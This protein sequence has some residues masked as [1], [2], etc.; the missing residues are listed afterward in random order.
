V[1]TTVK[2]EPLLGGLPWRGSRPAPEDARHVRL[3]RYPP[4]H[5]T[6]HFVERLPG[7]LVSL[8]EMADRAVVSA[9][10]PGGASI[11]FFAADGSLNCS[12]YHMQAALW[13]RE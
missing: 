7:F 12:C 9:Q 3:P 11:L 5:S 4:L 10:P 2:I 13:S 1:S 6:Q 8:V